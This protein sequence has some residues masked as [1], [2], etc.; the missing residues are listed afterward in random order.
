MGGEGRGC[1]VLR[2][3]TLASGTKR[4]GGRQSGDGGAQMHKNGRRLRLMHRY[5]D[6]LR[7]H[8]VDSYGCICDRRRRTS[9]LTLTVDVCGCPIWDFLCVPARYDGEFRGRLLA[10]RPPGF[11]PAPCGG[12]CS[13][14][15]Q[16]RPA[17]RP[18]PG[19]HSS[20]SPQA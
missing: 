2:S 8:R 14:P 17:P 7:S 5:F 18:P 12:L 9:S 1:Y 20:D 15:T 13:W 6:V 19:G 3:M 10:A 4:R 11:L 16:A